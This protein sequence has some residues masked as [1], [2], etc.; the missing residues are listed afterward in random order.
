M[1]ATNQEV[2]TLLT[3]SL[4]PVETEKLQKVILYAEQRKVANGRIIMIESLLVCLGVRM[5]KVYGSVFVWCLP[6]C[7]C[8][9]MCRLIATAAQVNELQVRVSSHIFLDFNLQK[10]IMACSQVMPIFG[11][12]LQPFQNSL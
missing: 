12:P 4:S 3:G 2:Y 6:V 11:M 7:V 8:V 10:L 1:A 9:C 5:R